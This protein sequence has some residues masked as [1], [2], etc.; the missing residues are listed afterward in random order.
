MTVVI[1]T[2]AGNTVRVREVLGKGLTVES[3]QVEF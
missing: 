3:P 2:T 1:I